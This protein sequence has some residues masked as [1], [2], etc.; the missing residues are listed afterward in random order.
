MSIRYDRAQLLQLTI[1][2]NMRLHQLAGFQMHD[3]AC[4]RIGLDE[5]FCSSVVDAE[6]GQ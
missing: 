1:A 2:G 3:H 4:G 5:I 6:T